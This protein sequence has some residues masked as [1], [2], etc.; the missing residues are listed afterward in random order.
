VCV[1]DPNHLS[2]KAQYK[3]QLESLKE[4]ILSFSRSSG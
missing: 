4:R 2:V 3:E 1:E